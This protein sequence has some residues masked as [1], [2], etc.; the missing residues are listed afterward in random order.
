VSGTSM[1]T[2]EAP[3]PTGD[4]RG[5]VDGDPLGV[6]G[7]LL[8]AVE[9]LAVVEPASVAPDELAELVRVLESVSS[10]LAA[11]SLRVL[12]DFDQRGV[13]EVVTAAYSAG[14]W[15]T[16]QTGTSRTDATARVRLA[17][18]LREMPATA[19]ALAAGEITVAHARALAR[20]LGPRTREAF[21]DAEADLVGHA[22][23]LSADELVRAVRYWMEL[24]DPDGPEPDSG[25]EASWFSCNRLPDGRRAL[26]GELDAAMGAEF[27]AALREKAEEI[28]RRDRR[29]SEIDPTD[30]AAG[31]TPTQR[32]AE[33][34]AELVGLGA[35]APASTKRRRPLLTVVIDDLTLADIFG[36]DRRQPTG[37]SGDPGGAGEPFAGVTHELLDGTVV[38]LETL[39]LWSCDAHL[40]RTV[41]SAAGEPLDVGREERFATDAQRRLLDVRDGGCAVPG[42]DRPASWCDA[43]HIE[44][45]EHGGRTDIDNLVLTCRHHHTRIHAGHLTVTM[46]DHHPRFHLRDG[47]EVVATRP[48]PPAP[49]E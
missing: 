8:G 15:L 11:Q 45:W 28:F 35:A 49:R 1:L 6:A 12:G 36:P 31:R 30:P 4:P 23:T 22:R 17:R 38:Q 48:P 13:W 47:T 16:H 33:A 29:H 7:A 25:E 43:H 21:V 9:R 34:L 2:A 14:N 32:R 40:C 20:G 10:R 39:R 37:D 18:A 41:F 5:G 27:E 46:V 42:C 44:F 3:A 26:R 19:A 24:V